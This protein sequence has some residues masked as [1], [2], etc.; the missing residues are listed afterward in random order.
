MVDSQEG[1][2]GRAIATMVER[3]AAIAARS[4]CILVWRL[5]EGI[6]KKKHPEPSEGEARPFQ[7][8]VERLIVAGELHPEM[9]SIAV[10]ALA[11]R[12]TA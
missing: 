2:G 8:E 6:P 5:G 4:T 11:A 10:D 7:A 12:K 3:C 1:F 9:G